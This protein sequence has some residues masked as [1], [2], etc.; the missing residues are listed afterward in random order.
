MRSVLVVDPNPSLRLSLRVQFAEYPLTLTECDGD[1]SA[2]LALAAGPDA[3][4]APAAQAR[5]LVKEM[6]RLEREPSLVLLYRADDA[7]ATE[8]L[9]RLAAE[10]HAFQSIE[11]SEAA[12]HVARRVV[13]ALDGRRSVRV[14]APKQARLRFRLDGHSC[15][16]AVFDVASHGLSAEVSSNFAVDRISPGV[17]LAR[18]SLF[19]GA[20]RLSTERTL[21][22]RSLRRVSGPGEMPRFVAGLA[23]QQARAEASPLFNTDALQVRA[24]LQR[25]LRRDEPFR[26]YGPSGV[27]LQTDPQDATITPGG[28]LILSSGLDGHGLREGDVISLVVD[29]GGQTLCGEVSILSV[30]AGR[31]MLSLPRTLSVSR[32]REGLR[33]VAPSSSG[34][35]AWHRCPFRNEDRL[36]LVERLDGSRVTLRVDPGAEALPPGLLIDPV[37]LTTAKGEVLLFRA[38]VETEVEPAPGGG[39]QVTLLLQG[40]SRKQ[41]SMLRNAAVA[42]RYPL[43]QPLL[44]VPFSDVWTLMRDSHQ[45]FPDYPVD[46][47]S[48]APRLCAA[49]EALESS[50]GELGR[51][52]VYTDQGRPMG[53]ASGLRIYR[54]TWLMGH[55]A[56]LPG[57]HRS[58]QASR[59]LSALALEYGEM[60]EDVD[61]VRYVWRTENR[62]PNRYS[63]WLS[64]RVGQ[65]SRSRLAF[66][67][68]LRCPVGALRPCPEAEN[69]V[70]RAERADLVA[71]E[72]H[73]RRNGN[74]V[75]LLSDDLTADTLELEQLSSRFAEVGLERRREVWVV[76]GPGAPAAFGLLERSTRGLSWPELTNALKLVVTTED[77]ERGDAAR[78]ALAVHAA[79]SNQARG[80][81]STVVLATEEDLAV[82]ATLGFESLGKT[83]EWTFARSLVGAWDNLTRAVTERFARRAA[84]QAARSAEAVVQHT[85]Q[86]A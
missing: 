31:L 42:A 51:S 50:D 58:D 47:P 43:A 48:C 84:G 37:V 20:Q 41:A 7:A 39:G 22:V 61:F 10:G 18:A 19:S 74:L 68:Y 32:G 72:A 17:V 3:V 15:S 27:V 21:V 33:F 63:S 26:L 16:L 67:H 71:L 75:T 57:F 28:E 56:V 79:E 30:G 66:F 2:A 38:E 35:R 12:V 13:R 55:L 69:L 29:F 86:A 23:Y 62:W 9:A 49:Q 60:L 81:P 34:W 40:V 77:A 4:V 11:C 80:M 45:F 44:T 1:A 54:R 59:E 76:D 8:V 14:G 64:R 53:H 85:E 46:D 70:R 6:E 25:A 36:H 78:R 83:A 52:Y 24:T 73:L 65:E 5:R 82:L